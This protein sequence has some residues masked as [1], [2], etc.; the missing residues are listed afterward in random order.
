MMGGILLL[1]NELLF[2]LTERTHFS[3]HQVQENPDEGAIS[4]WD[5]EF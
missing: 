2:R 4:A 1:L 5:Q 3:R